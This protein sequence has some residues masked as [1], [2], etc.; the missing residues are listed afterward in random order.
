MKEIINAKIREFSELVQSALTKQQFVDAFK[1]V[2]DY[3]KRVEISLNSKVDA[4][5]SEFD[6]LENLYQETLKKLEAENTSSLSNIKKWALEK[7]GQ[8]FVNS[9]INEKID[10][11]DD[12]LAEFNS[13]ELPNA[14]KIA[15]EASKMAQEG[16]LPL[17][18]I[19]DKLE[20][21]LP[22]MGDKIADA[23]EALPEKKKLI[24]EA[25][26]GLREELD[27]LRTVR[28]RVGGG[29]NYMGIIQHFVFDETPT[30][31][32]DNLNFTINTIPNPT[33]SLRVYKNGQR[34][35]IGAAKDYT[36]SNTTITLLTE[37]LATDELTVDYMT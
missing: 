28:T 19:V 32:G 30:N 24:I 14:S 12:K 2:L 37:K 36:F 10:E 33:D 25:I 35:K 17:I 4:K 6:R 31:S 1:N 9:K 27:E 8:L 21:K 11:L 7:V 20:E 22:Q 5:L 16:L 3:V 18:P 23:L 26:K 29:T 13:Y 34:L 15:L